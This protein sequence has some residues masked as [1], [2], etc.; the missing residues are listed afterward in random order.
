M[1]G[2]GTF[3]RDVILSFYSGI[4][5]VSDV[6]VSISSG[7]FRIIEQVLLLWSLSHGAQRPISLKPCLYAPHSLVHVELSTMASFRLKCLLSLKPSPYTPRSLVQGR[8]ST[9]ADFV[10]HL[11]CLFSNLILP[12]FEKYQDRYGRVK[13]VVLAQLYSFDLLK[14]SYIYL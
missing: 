11:R 1:K 2:C 6:L 9:M 5:E 12:L 7:R 4:S 13:N 14:I 8:L 3:D 10:F